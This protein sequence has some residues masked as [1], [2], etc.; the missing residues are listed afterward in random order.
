[1]HVL[2]LHAALRAALRTALHESTLP[3]QTQTLNQRVREGISLFTSNHFSGQFRSTGGC[4][5]A[6]GCCVYN[7]F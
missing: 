7:F 1:M 5:G 2:H 3:K 4:P 6:F